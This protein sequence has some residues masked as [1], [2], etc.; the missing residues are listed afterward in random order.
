MPG[1]GKKKRASPEGRAK[2]LEGR[3][4]ARRR[5]R[6]AV[7]GREEKHPRCDVLHIWACCSFA[8]Q[9]ADM[10]GMRRAHVAS[11]LSMISKDNWRGE[12]GGRAYKL[13]WN[14]RADADEVRSGRFLRWIGCD[15]RW[16]R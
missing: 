11:N 2:P 3:A 8:N 5:E 4:E 9:V 16:R 6:S 12:A 15:I 10:S 1:I 7:Q 14:V 13:G